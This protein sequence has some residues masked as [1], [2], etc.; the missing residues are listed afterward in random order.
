LKKASPST[1][2]EKKVYAYLKEML[3][4]KKEAK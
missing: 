3:Q 1:A 2:Q 4:G